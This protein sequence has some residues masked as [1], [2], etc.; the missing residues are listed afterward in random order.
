MSV[1]GGYSSATTFLRHPVGCRILAGQSC[2]LS[3][4][5][6]K[7]SLT[8]Q[9]FVLWW[10]ND[11]LVDKDENVKMLED[12]NGSKCTNISYKCLNDE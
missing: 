6:D 3:C 9:Y 1:C 11:R 8:E 2:K 12:S 4:V 7:T 10:K 5:V